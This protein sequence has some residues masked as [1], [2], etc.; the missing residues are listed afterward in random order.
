MDGLGH[1]HSHS[2]HAMLISY[3]IALCMC[4]LVRCVHYSSEDWHLVRDVPIQPQQQYDLTSYGADLMMVSDGFVTIYSPYSHSRMMI[5]GHVL[6]LS[7]GASYAVVAI[8]TVSSLFV[9]QVFCVGNKR[10][11]NCNAI[12][13][14]GTVPVIPTAAPTRAPSTTS[15]PTLL[16]SI[17]PSIAPTPAPTVPLAA[18]TESPTCPYPKP[19]LAPTCPP[20]AEDDDNDDEDEQPAA[21]MLSVLPS[22][23]PAKLSAALHALQSDA[24]PKT[25]PSIEPAAVVRRSA[26]QAAVPTRAEC[27]IMGQS[28]TSFGEHM[29]LIE[30]SLLVVTASIAQQHFL[31]FYLLVSPAWTLQQQI[32]TTSPITALY[33]S[34]PHI[35]FTTHSSIH[36]LVQSES[37]QLFSEV[38]VFANTGSSAFG[39]CSAE[40]MAID[41]SYAAACCGSGSSL[42]VWKFLSTQ[43]RWELDTAIAVPTRNEEL[44]GCFDLQ[45]AGELAFLSKPT[46]AFAGQ[47]AIVY[48]LRSRLQVGIISFPDMGGSAQ[49][50]L[51]TKAAT[52]NMLYMLAT[53]EASVQLYQLPLTTSVSPTSRPTSTPTPGAAPADK[54]VC[55]IKEYQTKSGAIF[56]RHFCFPHHSIA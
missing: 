10:W 32:C 33:A 4:S 13:D 37:N 18:P 39:R 6:S 15:A 48:N 56:Y 2:L 49:F 17:A 3:L 26:S 36:F 7:L 35:V 34:E 40:H 44:D 21:A 1:T 55:R 22:T 45:I 43:M 28:L 31:L 50:E 42:V 12:V 19:T 46:S 38:S 30:P 25:C 16:P 27:N 52:D 29:V 20:F 41:G 51:H 11:T 53:S 5:S 23:S 14:I 9:L 8:R 24:I 47:H 54:A